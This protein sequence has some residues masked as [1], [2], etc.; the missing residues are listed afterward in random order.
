VISFVFNALTTDGATGLLGRAGT[1]SFDSVKFQT[2]DVTLPQAQSTPTGTSAQAAKIAAIEIP[3]SQSGIFEVAETA[4]LAPV[5]SPVEMNL[6]PK[7]PVMGSLVN[8]LLGVSMPSSFTA[9]SFIGD[10]TPVTSHISLLT[11]NTGVE[12]DDLL[13][14]GLSTHIPSTDARLLGESG[15]DR[16]LEAVRFDPPETSSSGQSVQAS[17]ENDARNDE[18][19]ESRDTV[20]KKSVDDANTVAPST[21]AASGTVIEPASRDVPPPRNPDTRGDSE[22]PPVDAD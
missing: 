16:V 6:A 12:R 1:T 11:G 8:G 3:S 18:G 13:S 14:T 15:E 5:S 7:G 4:S 17:A 20:E 2:D 9:G 22:E 21:A 10:S 19:I